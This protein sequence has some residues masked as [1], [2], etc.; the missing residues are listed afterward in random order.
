MVMRIPC[1]QIICLGS[2]PEPE[3]VLRTV[4]LSCVELLQ[5]LAEAIIQKFMTEEHAEIKRGHHPLLPE[6]SPYTLFLE[7][8]PLQSDLFRSL[9]K[10][11]LNSKQMHGFEVRRKTCIHPYFAPMGILELR[12]VGKPSTV[13][14]AVCQA[15]LCVIEK[16]NEK[17]VNV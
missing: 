16:K 13:V 12:R 1:Y 11:E 6:A 7:N 15:S 14:Q 17:S 9:E 2:K 5:N 3:G 8:P 10:L 4:V